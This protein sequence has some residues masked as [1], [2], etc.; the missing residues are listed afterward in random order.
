M[1][2]ETVRHLASLAHIAVTDAEC[3]A[4]A[5]DLIELSELAKALEALPSER[6]GFE[7]AI[8]LLQLREDTVTEGLAREALLQASPHHDA[9]T[10][11]VPRTVEE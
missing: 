6:D 4:L 8:D 2:K 5:R 1:N 9:E 7:G 11:L 3:E 10:I